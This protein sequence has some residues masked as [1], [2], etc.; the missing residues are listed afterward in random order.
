ML[1]RPWNGEESMP[2]S[3][4]RHRMLREQQEEAARR[5]LIE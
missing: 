2:H 5:V 1:E 3:D 4:N